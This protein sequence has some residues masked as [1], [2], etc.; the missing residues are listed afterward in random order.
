[1]ISIE[2]ETILFLGFNDVT[3]CFISDFQMVVRQNKIRLICT[4]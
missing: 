4:K 1:M 3:F 2:L